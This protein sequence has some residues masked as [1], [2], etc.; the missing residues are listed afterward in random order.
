MIA[1]NE[2]PMIIIA[3]VHRAFEVTFRVG[4]AEIEA[5]AVG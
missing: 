3:Y 1:P 5:V 4:E 2:P